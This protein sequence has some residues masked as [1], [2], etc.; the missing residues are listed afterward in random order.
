MGK[1]ITN[2]GKDINDGIMVYV[3]AEGDGTAQTLS[4]TDYDN[5]VW[6][7]HSDTTHAGRQMYWLTRYDGGGNVVHELSL[8]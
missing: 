6:I 8:G 4:Y 3:L 2:K 1:N 5:A 7:V